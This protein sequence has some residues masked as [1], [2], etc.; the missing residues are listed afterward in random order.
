MSKNDEN[1]FTFHNIFRQ[2][3][4][5]NLYYMLCLAYFDVILGYQ[6]ICLVLTKKKKNKKRTL[7]FLPNPTLNENR[8][9]I[10]DDRYLQWWQTRTEREKKTHLPTF[11][12]FTPAIFH[13]LFFLVFFCW[14]EKFVKVKEADKSFHPT[15]E[16][17]AQTFVYLVHLTIYLFFSLCSVPDR[18]SILCR[19]V[20]GFDLMTYTLINILDQN[21]IAN[22]MRSIIIEF[23]KNLMKISHK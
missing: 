11:N 7:S 10:F 16:I 15:I 8:K 22:F 5:F 13:S 4:L 6:S 19:N 12:S 2:Y 1:F 18:N 14:I 17:F 20:K 23:D 3:V 21:K 9:V